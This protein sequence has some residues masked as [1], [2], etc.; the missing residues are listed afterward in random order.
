ML[1]GKPWTKDAK[2]THDWGN[3]VIIVQDNRIIITIP[4]NKKLGAKTKRPQLLVCYDLMEG[5]IDE[6]ED[7]IFKIEPKLFSNGIT[8]ISNEIVSLL[9]V[10]VT[11]FIIHG[12][13]EPKQGISYKGIVKVVAST[14]KTNII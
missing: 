9:S 13:F 3:N 10:G 14:T 8:T 2:V 4:V 5:L 11:Y 1:L 12:K 6:E 7:Q